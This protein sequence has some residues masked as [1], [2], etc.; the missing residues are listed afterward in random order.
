MRTETVTVRPFFDLSSAI[1]D[2]VGKC[3]L[4]VEVGGERSR[5]PEKS[6]EISLD[7]SEVTL[8][9]EFD[10][11]LLGNVLDAQ[12]SGAWRLAAILTDDTRRR[13]DLLKDVELRV[14]A[15]SFAIGRPQSK[16]SWSGR[17]GGVLSILVYFGERAEPRPGRPF[18]RGHV[19]AAKHFSINKSPI[20]VDFPVR[21]V[22][23]K[24]LRELGYPEDTVVVVRG[25]AE[26]LWAEKVEDTDLQILVH[27]RMR[28]A[29]HAARVTKRQRQIVESVKFL[30]LL[31]LAEMARSVEGVVEAGTL[32]YRLRE[33]LSSAGE[34]G[35]LSLDRLRTDEL[36][37]IVQSK[38]DLLRSYLAST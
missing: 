21:F 28:P 16:A 5:Y 32:A 25:S 30:A 20:G 15:P 34:H 33:K 24:S 3:V 35:R 14:A 1:A 23:P 7:P 18:R 26:Q 13:S 31:Q 27:E 19:L 9:V 11:N 22:S 10:E 8:S 38:S 36:F 37:A 4:V 17:N 29:F 2:L 12:E 6:I